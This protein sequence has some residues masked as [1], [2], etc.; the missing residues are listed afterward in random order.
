MLPTYFNLGHR[1][2]RCDHS[3]HPSRVDWPIS[4][5]FRHHHYRL[6]CQRLFYC[7]G[8]TIGCSVLLFAKILR[9]HGP[10]GEEAG[11]YF[12]VTY[13][14]P[15]WWNS[16]GRHDHSGLRSHSTVHRYQWKE[17]RW[18]PSLLLS[19]FCQQ[20]MAGGSTR[21]ALKNYTQQIKPSFFKTLFI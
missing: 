2:R 10:S 11:I 13:L 16:I 3:G 21:E 20:S 7:C 9:Q 8:Y 14:Q 17:N 4:G 6:L 12:E 5:C 15:L 1:H 18:Q 19:N